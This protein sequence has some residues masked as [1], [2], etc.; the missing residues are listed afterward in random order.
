MKIEVAR[1]KSGGRTAGTPNRATAA[2]RALAGEHAETAITTLVSLMR[3]ETTP[4]AARISAAKELLERGFGRSSS[5]VSLNLETPL[6]VLSPA[7]ALAVINDKAATGEI[8]VDEAV[9]LVNL[10][11]AKMKA[12]E[13]AELETRLSALETRQ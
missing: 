5:Y 10:I 8:A 7:E 6:S 4:A 1:E 11:E 2:I 3:D 9:K 12:V 13:L